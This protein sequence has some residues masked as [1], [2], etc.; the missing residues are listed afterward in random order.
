MKTFI[1]YSS[2]GVSLDSYRNPQAAVTD[3]ADV[4]AAL[5]EE[6]EEVLVCS[7]D[8]SELNLLEDGTHWQGSN[9]SASA[10]E[11]LHDLISPN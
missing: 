11:Q 2:T 9:V 3:F 7:L 6:R 4:A 10:L 5:T 1:N 8:G